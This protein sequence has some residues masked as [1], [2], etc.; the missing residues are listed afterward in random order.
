MKRVYLGTLF[1]AVAL[2][3]QSA[4][5]IDRCGLGGNIHDCHCVE[6]TDSIHQKIV[7][8]CQD[9][10]KTDKE[11]STCIKSEM[12]AHCDIAESSTKWDEGAFEWD[13]ATQEYKGHSGM[14]ELCSR[15]CKKHRCSC[16]DGPHCD[17]GMSSEDSK[18]ADREERR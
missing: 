17:F 6:R 2:A 5:K 12:M 13:S 8:Y 11:R 4:P 1:V 9:Q 3:Q 14:G 16:A 7:S 18:Q 10:Y 15:A